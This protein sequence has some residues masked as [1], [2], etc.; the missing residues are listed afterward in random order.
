MYTS[1]TVLTLS[2]NTANQK[3]RPHLPHRLSVTSATKISFHLPLGLSDKQS[4]SHH[5]PPA[6]STTVSI[7]PSP[8]L[9]DQM[10]LSALTYPTQI[11]YLPRGGSVPIVRAVLQG[12]SCSSLR[13]RVWVVDGEGDLEK[14]W[15]GWMREVGME[16]GFGFLCMGV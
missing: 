2:P 9:F 4:P 3:S 13:V 6:L 15:G 16:G 8:D 14:V 12:R 7:S 11:D 1:L 5:L 10:C